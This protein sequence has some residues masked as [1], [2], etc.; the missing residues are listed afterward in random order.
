MSK[1]S[2][3]GESAVALELSALTALFGLTL[4]Q[5]IR[6]RR[7]LVL[8]FLFSLPAVLILIIRLSDVNPSP[9]VDKLEF[10]LIFT[11]IPHSLIPLTTLLYASGMIQ[12]ELEE[13]T[14]TYLLVRPLPKWA[15][16]GV[17]LLAI[18]VLTA[19]LSAA[20]L[21]V[22]YF[23]LY[24][25]QESLPDELWLRVGKTIGA[26]SLAVGAYVSLFACISL[27][28]RRSLVVGVGYIILFEG[29]LANIDFVVR[30]LTIMYWFRV[31]L[32]HWLSESHEEW[33]LDMKEAPTAFTCVLTLAGI[34]L[35][36]TL[37]GMFVFSQ[38]EFRLKT[39]EGS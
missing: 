33:S 26:V 1:V 2:T 5:Q 34:I 32:L 16:Y 17:K 8:L 30:R 14:L 36:S 28:I 7:L 19:S 35:T 25:G 6:T 3:H 21:V 31:L 24:V 13:Q 11:L 27:V 9:R 12:D 38:R 37:I 29:V 20:L 22:T 39:P 15:L 18:F 23:S 10:A 4:R